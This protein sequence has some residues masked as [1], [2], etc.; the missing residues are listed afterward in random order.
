MKISTA[1][2]LEDRAWLFEQYPVLQGHWGT[3]EG[4]PGCLL[5][6]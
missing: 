4:A 6:Y 2:N 3:F 1:T 5:S